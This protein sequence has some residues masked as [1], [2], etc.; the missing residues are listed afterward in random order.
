MAG[1][2]KENAQGDAPKIDEKITNRAIEEEL[3]ESYLTYAMSVIVARALPDIRDGL[4]PVQR[5]ILFTMH[6]MGVHHN[7]S[8]KKSAR[9]VGDILGKY[10]PHGD[11]AIY[12]ALVRMAQDFSLRYPTVIGQGNFGSQDGDEPAHQRYTEVKLAK[13]SDEVLQDIEKETVLFVPNYS[14]EFVEPTYLPSKLPNLLLN[15]SSGIAV[16]MAT[17]IPPHN[18][19][20][21]CDGIIKT[22]E[23]PQI[24]I[25]EL[26][27][28]IK[29][30]DFPTGGIILGREGVRAAYKLGRGKIK[31]RAKARIEENTIIVEEVPY[32]ANKA[33]IIEEVATL[34]RKEKIKDIKAIR[35]ESSRNEIRIVIECRAAP[36]I[37]LNNLYKHTGLQSTQGIIM[38]ALDKNRPKLFNLKEIISSY[39][40]HRVEIITNRTKYDLRK[41][42]E[43]K[44]ILE[45]FLIA[46]A[47]IDEVVKTIKSSKN[48]DE[49]KIKLVSGFGLSDAQADAI[50]NM[51]LSQLTSLEQEQIREEDRQLSIKISLYKTLLSSRENILAEIRR[52]VLELRENYKD[53]RRTQLSDDPFEIPD[54][55]LMDDTRNLLSIT[56][57]NYLKLISID[58]F[59]IQGRG[60]KGIQAT[61]LRE[62]DQIKFILPVN[63]LDKVLLFTR[64]GKV[65]RIKAY[66]IPRK[67]RHTFG[68]PIAS[69]IGVQEDIVGVIA[70][71]EFSSGDIIFATRK[72][73]TKRCSIKLF[74]RI[75]VTGKKAI[76]L[77]EGDDLVDVKFVRKEDTNIL[78]VTKKGKAVHFPKSDLRP[79]GRGARGVGGIRVTFDDRVVSL[80]SS[81][82]KK[83]KLFLISEKGFGKRTQI[84]GIR[85][86]RR[87]GKGVRVFKVSPKTGDVVK[88]FIVEGDEEVF[89]ITK[90]GQIIR[91]EASEISEQGRYSHGVRVIKLDEK[92]VVVNA[93]PEHKSVEQR[94]LG[95]KDAIKKEEVE[96]G[97]SEEELIEKHT[98]KSG[99]SDNILGDVEENN[100]EEDN[101]EDSIF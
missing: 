84:G 95:G 55:Q 13:I 52:E 61:K 96:G 65:Y 63:Y 35:D 18:V 93:I 30:P 20:E 85:E 16:G 86:T 97:P 34:V 82:D 33:T 8:F 14:N 10:H 6:E 73:R 76:L 77:E 59:R 80:C 7:R 4:K 42:E 11:A 25:D 44:H 23:N 41:A 75:Q 91:T 89:A 66:R 101:D 100:L 21:V 39:I 46:L 50:L 1:K 40:E 90:E 27:T 74:E 64:S 94:V 5:R 29:G 99:I 2:D 79:M 49:A 87:R 81:S 38:L 19:L 67:E 71:N 48:R 62:E 36:E 47:S 58:E 92:D 45:G 24:E 3:K 54:E 17:N 51:R 37:V 72:G 53:E 22:I 26:I 43:R 31:V 9:V 88:A 56:N 68:E 70:Q 15:G 98:Q 12:A 28:I 78:I 69:I 83:Q 60:G 32:Q 57:N